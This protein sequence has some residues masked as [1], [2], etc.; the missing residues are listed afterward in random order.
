M[1]IVLILFSLNIK[2]YIFK[3]KVLDKCINMLYNII[4]RKTNKRTK[5]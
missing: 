2:I 5:T 1:K 4:V 3:E